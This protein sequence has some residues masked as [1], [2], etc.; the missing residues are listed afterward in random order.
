MRVH[1]CVNRRMVGEGV[2]F[3]CVAA[4]CGHAYLCSVYAPYPF[5]PVKATV[6]THVAV[7]RLVVL[8]HAATLGTLNRLGWPV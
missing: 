2:I 8:E 1:G 6:E 3:V 7:E 5:G 4:T